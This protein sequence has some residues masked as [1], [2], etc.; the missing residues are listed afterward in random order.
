MHDTSLLNSQGNLK[1]MVNQREVLWCKHFKPH[2]SILLIMQ[3]IASWKN[4]ELLPRNICSRQKFTQGRVV[5]S[6]LQ[7]R[8]C[9]W[10][11]FITLKF[12]T[13]GKLD[14]RFIVQYVDY[15]NV[16]IKVPKI[17]CFYNLFFFNQEQHLRQTISFF[18][19]TTPKHCLTNTVFIETF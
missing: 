2:T 5:C 10:S 9:N 12:D 1:R 18:M 11:S 6:L 7:K 17:I 3:D 14:V 8:L 15:Q 16:K 13:S 19:Q 4:N